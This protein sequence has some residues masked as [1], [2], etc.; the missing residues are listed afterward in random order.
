LICLGFDLC[1]FDF[2]GFFLI[3]LGFD[4][5]SFDF[6]GFFLI[7]LGFDLF[8]FDFV[9]F[10]LICF[11]CWGWRVC[12]VCVFDVENCGLR[13]TCFCSSTSDE[14]CAWVGADVAWVGADVAWVGAGVAGWKRG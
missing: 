9:D 8:S 6:V 1:S 5:F 13:L 4:L 2:V 14:C 3:C 10:F 12:C 11:D 7:W